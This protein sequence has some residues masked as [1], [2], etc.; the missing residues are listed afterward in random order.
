M[1]NAMQPIAA[2]AVT[3][4][5]GWSPKVRCTRASSGGAASRCGSGRVLRNPSDW[6]GMPM[7]PRNRG[8]LRVAIGGKNRPT[9]EQRANCRADSDGCAG[10]EN[11]AGCTGWFQLAG[12]AMAG[13]KSFAARGVR[14]DNTSGT[15]WSLHAICSDRGGCRLGHPRADDRLHRIT[16]GI[17]GSLLASPLSGERR[18]W[19]T[20]AVRSTE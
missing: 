4:V 9:S 8:G 20:S 13:W 17:P 6:T 18:C 5:D 2:V 1:N 12:P 3:A 7:L 11:A 15:R 16:P 10:P 19:S 14:A